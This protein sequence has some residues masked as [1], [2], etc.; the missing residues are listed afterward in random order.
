MKLSREKIKKNQIWLSIQF[1]IWPWKGGLWVTSA[2]KTREKSWVSCLLKLICLVWKCDNMLSIFWVYVRHDSTDMTQT[3][4]L[5]QRTQ[6]HTWPDLVSRRSLAT[7]ETKTLWHATFCLI[8][9]VNKVKIQESMPGVKS[10]H[11][12]SFIVP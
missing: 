1:R 9:P 3:L 12:N 8:P 5:V 4:S 10:K 11:N 6:T 7:C 2:Y